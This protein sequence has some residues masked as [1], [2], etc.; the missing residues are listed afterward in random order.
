MTIHNIYKPP[1]TSWSTQALPILQHP[2]VYV[3]DFNSHHTQWK[4]RDNDD[5]GEALVDWA[6]EN[7]MYLVFDA[8]DKDSFYSAA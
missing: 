7:N 6:E 8:K 4:Y 5:N 2:S 1:A 3:G